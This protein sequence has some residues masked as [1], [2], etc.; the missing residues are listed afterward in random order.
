MK[1]V[2]RLLNK[3]PRL[4]IFI[5]SSISSIWF[6]GADVVFLV[7]LE[8]RLAARG[9]TIVSEKA[10]VLVYLLIIFS[11]TLQRAPNS[12]RSP[13]TKHQRKALWQKRRASIFGDTPVDPSTLHRNVS[14]LFSLYLILSNDTDD[15]CIFEV[16]GWIL[17]QIAES[18][19][20]SKNMVLSSWSWKN[21]ALF[22]PFLSVEVDI[23][24]LSWV[25][26]NWY[27]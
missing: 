23:I 8:G 26:N 11:L 22:W 9:H 16:S 14:L 27:H 3:L 18:S 6:I 25:L 7:R 5:S 2:Q 13:Q 17:N 4:C 1:D 21:T 12:L 24:Y 20:F 15:E 10:E 19:H